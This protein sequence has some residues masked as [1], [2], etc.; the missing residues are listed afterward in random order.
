M[1]R[2][3]QFASCTKGTFVRGTAPSLEDGL[4]QLRSMDSDTIALF[5]AC[6]CCSLL[7]LPSDKYGLGL[8]TPTPVQGIQP[9]IAAG[10][11]G[12]D[13]DGGIVVNFAP[14]AELVVLLVQDGIDD[15]VLIGQACLPA[16]S[17]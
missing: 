13:G 16:F 9:R 1:L 5:H 8:V 11:D 6:T 14:F 12:D 2:S 4:I 10:L 17:G 15:V 7:V 3:C